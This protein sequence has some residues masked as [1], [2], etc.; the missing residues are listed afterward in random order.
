MSNRDTN[1]MK[2]LALKLR[3]GVPLT[4]AEQAEWNREA[5]WQHRLPLLAAQLRAG[6]TLSPGDQLYWNE[7]AN[8]HDKLAAGLPLTPEEQEKVDRAKEAITTVRSGGVMVVEAPSMDMR[9]WKEQIAKSRG[10]TGPLLAPEEKP[11]SE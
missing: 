3:A 6:A 5:G 7:N 4:D 10:Q 11:K 1:R 2:F 9:Q 8:A